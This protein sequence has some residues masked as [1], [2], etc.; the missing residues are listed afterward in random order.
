MARNPARLDNRRGVHLLR[1]K[2]RRSLK[3]YPPPVICGTAVDA[4]RGLG[5]AKHPQGRG[6][7]IAQRC[8]GGRQ[9]QPVVASRGSVVGHR[10]DIPSS[11]LPQKPHVGLW[12]RSPP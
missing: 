6:A 2:I 11:M 3:R 8:N 5:V 4:S 9:G 1:Q 7:L 12:A 10:H